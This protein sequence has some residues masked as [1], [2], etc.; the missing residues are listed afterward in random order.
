MT[1]KQLIALAC[2]AAPVTSLLAP[3]SATVKTCV[4]INQ[5]VGRTQQFFTMSFLG[6]DAP[7]LAPSG[8][9][10]A[11]L[12]RHRARAASMAWRSTRRL[13]DGVAVP[14]PHRSTQRGHVIVEK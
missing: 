7:V 13:L 2:A 12:P 11:A 8:G 4:E 5:C 10:E 3:R 1:I 14:V 9:D 6:D